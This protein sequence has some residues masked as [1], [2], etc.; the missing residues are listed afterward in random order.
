MTATKIFLYEELFSAAEKQLVESDTLSASVFRYKSGVCAVRIKNT[1]GELIILPYQGQQIWRASFCGKDLTMKTQFDEPENTREFLD[2]YGGFLLHCGA[3][4][5][6]NPSPEDTHPSHGEFPNFPYRDAYVELGE[7]EKGSYIAVG[8]SGAYRKSFGLSYVANPKITLYENDSVF[9]ASMTIENKSIHPLEYMYL[10][11]INFRPEDGAKIICTAEKDSM[12]YFRDIPENYDPIREAALTDYMNRMD[13]DITIHETIDSSTQAYD[14]E[15]VFDMRYKADAEGRAHCM[16]KLPAGDGYY[17]SHRPE[18]LPHGIRWISRRGDED[19]I[20]M[21]LP[22]TAVHKGR[23]Y[24]EQHNM[25]KV[26]AGGESITF[27][28][29]AG[30]LAKECVAAK[31]QQIASVMNN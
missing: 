31:E 1:L 10:C 19:A 24:A 18:Q 11:H 8:G 15:I 28:V 23:I 9:E 17:V 6:G 5:M 27:D 14:P 21:L 3:T 26:L 29:R 13:Q 12:K 16:L 25:I 7:N 20:G 2:T 22:A 4:A 30:Y